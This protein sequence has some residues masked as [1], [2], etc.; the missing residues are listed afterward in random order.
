MI[1][2]ARPHRIEIPAEKPKAA[3][4]SRVN[5][6][7]VIF[8]IALVSIASFLVIGAVIFFADIANMLVLTH[9][10]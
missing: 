9:R 7:K 1:E 8:K 5:Y 2:L 10:E 3:I 6:T 4:A